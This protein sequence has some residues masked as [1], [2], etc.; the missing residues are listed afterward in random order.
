MKRKTVAELK[1]RAERS[2]Q[3]YDSGQNEALL[4]QWPA[5]EFFKAINESTPMEWVDWL[6]KWTDG[7]G[8]IFGNR[9]IALKNDPVWA[10]ISK[11]NLP[12]SPFDEYDVMDVRDIEREV[13]ES[14]GLILRTQSVQPVKRIWADDKKQIHVS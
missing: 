4:D 2:F 14:F 11:F 9:M 6:K 12:Y 8:K 7:G 3:W 13:A 5:Q 1:I 10:R